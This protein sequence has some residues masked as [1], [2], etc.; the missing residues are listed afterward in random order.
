MENVGE[1][2]GIS[3]QSKASDKTEVL[4]IRIKNEITADTLLNASSD[5]AILITPDG[6]II[7]LN[8]IAAT[9]IGTSKKSMLGK[10]FYN[11]VAPKIAEESKILTTKIIK[12]R[13]A[14]SNFITLNGKRFEMKMNPILNAE[15]NVYRIAFFTK[16]ISRQYKEKQAKER[17]ELDKK[18]LTTN[19]LSDKLKY[20]TDSIVTIFDVDFARIWLVKPGDICENDCNY[21]ASSGSRCIRKD[22]CLHLVSSSGRYTGIKGKNK[23]I[24]YGA[25][26]IG[27]IAAHVHH[28]YLSNDITNNH[29]SLDKSWAK[30][31]ELRAF[32]GY[33]IISEQGKL[34]GVLSLFSKNR[35]DA[36]TD[37]I[38]ESLANTA[39]QVITAVQ[40]QEAREALLLKQNKLVEDTNIGLWEWDLKTNDV[41]YSAAWKK[42]MGELSEQIRN[43]FEEWKMRVHA[44]DLGQVLDKINSCLENRILDFT[45]E[46]RFKHTDGTYRWIYVQASILLGNNKQ[47]TRLVG[48]NLDITERKYIEAE[49]RIKNTTKDKFFSI[50]AHDLKGPIGAMHEFSDV[51]LNNFNNYKKPDLE[52]FLK[53]FNQNISNVHHLL[54]DLLTWSRS[55]QNRI[56]LNFEKFS[57]R[58]YTADTI[59]LTQAA[60]NKKNISIHNNTMAEH[61]IYADRQTSDTILRNLLSNAVKFTPLNGKINIFSQKINLHNS[62]YIEIIV[63]DN[64]IGIPTEKI[65]KLFSTDQ[66]TSTKG[67]DKEEGTGLGLIL[68]KEFI[69]KNGG[70]I[71]I[72]SEVNHG[73]TVRYTLPSK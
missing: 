61:I 67:T 40:N 15:G 56:E 35:I 19:N 52:R 36:D 53:I 72:E 30:Q 16:D 47:P 62:K 60:A 71:K 9:Q 39:S 14:V 45:T 3:Q 31:L 11:F 69:T 1:Q 44:D 20:L 37:I 43:S 54:D 33:Q 6:T 64:G 8:N 21:N 50:V 13:E 70:T 63:S 5:G 38:F 26:K 66:N 25:F 12:T 41:Y 46:F 59:C 58:L 51:I 57:S 23:R 48:S 55:Q 7:E 24:P 34:L 2:Y 68:C 10:C 18:L 42:H 32:A 65:D 27:E 22:K 73:T 4:P 29:D 28:R 17:I 49:L